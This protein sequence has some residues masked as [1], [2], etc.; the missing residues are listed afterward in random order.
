[1]LHTKFCE[2]RLAGSGEEDFWRVFN[3]YGHGGHLGHVT[4]MLRA[5][6]RSPYTRRFHIKFGFDWPSGFGEE[7]LWALWTMTDKDGRRTDAGRT[8]DHEYSISSPMSL[9]LRK[10]WCWSHDQDGSHPYMVKSL[11]NILWNQWI[12]FQELLNVAK[13]T[14]THHSLFKLW[15]WDDLDLF[16]GKLK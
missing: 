13:G 14:W 9:P 10:I 1:M 12:V 7:D 15:P 2:N 3:I 11:Q 6:F 5:I 8:T 4:E 16:Y